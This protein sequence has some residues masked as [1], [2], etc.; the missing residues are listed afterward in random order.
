[1]EF[2]QGHG[3][4]ILT[5]ILGLI[6]LY[7]EYRAL[8][9]LWIVGIIMPA[10][11]VILFTSGGLYAYAALSVIFTLTAIYGLWRWAASPLG[12]GRPITLITRGPL[13]AAVAGTLPLWGLG[14]LLLN[15][16]TDSTVPALDSLV[17]AISLTAM[18]LMARKYA[19]QWLLWVLADA[20]SVILLLGQG[21]PYRAA[22]YALYAAIA[23]LGYRKWKSL[24]RAAP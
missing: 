22:L 17:S 16:C 13:L 18:L 21:L 9:A 4:E 6:Y 24:A 15:N 12:R 8:T 20:L 5:T 7:L 10:L 3:L 23:V 2:L 19:E 1:M 14:W 11:D